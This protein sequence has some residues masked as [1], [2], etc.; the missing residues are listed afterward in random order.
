[1]DICLFRY[2]RI[3]LVMGVK[4][5]DALHHPG[6]VWAGKFFF[7][8]FLSKITSWQTRY[9]NMSQSK[10]HLI[11]PTCQLLETQLGLFHWRLLLLK[12]GGGEEVAY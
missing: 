6:C 1:M 12:A 4:L 11:G 7:F 10:I 9:A 2:L 5:C 3:I 8:F